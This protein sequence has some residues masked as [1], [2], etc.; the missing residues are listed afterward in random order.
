[1]S[2]SEVESHFGCV[3][4]ESDTEGEDLVYFMNMDFRLL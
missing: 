1:M 2:V 3:R 4:K